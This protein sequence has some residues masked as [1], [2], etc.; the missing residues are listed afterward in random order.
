MMIV[1]TSYG[2]WAQSQTAMNMN[3]GSAYEKADKELNAVYRKILKEYA[4]QPQFI[5][6]LKVAQRLWI[7]LRDAELA[8][9]YPERGSY[10]SVA[11]MCESIYLETLTKE[12]TK[13]LRMWLTGIPEGDVCAGS[14]KSK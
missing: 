9:K 2:A 13:F 12:R 4:A 11:P 14:V 7:Q 3:A 10:G 6:K 8:A 5:K 1:F